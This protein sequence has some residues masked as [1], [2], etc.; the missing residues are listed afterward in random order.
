MNVMKKI[1]VTGLY[2]IFGKLPQRAFPLLEA[3]RSKSGILEKTGLTV[4]INNASFAVQE[5]EIFVV[6]GLSGSGKSTVI[7]CLN[8]LI[9][10]P[11][12]KCWWMVKT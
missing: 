8:R 2:K 1:E 11:G 3:G 7:R 10:P 4:G 5:G 12:E 6:M 9:R